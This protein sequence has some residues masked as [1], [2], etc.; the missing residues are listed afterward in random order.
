M[1]C[2]QRRHPTHGHLHASTRHGDSGGSLARSAS[3]FFSRQRLERLLP[4]GERLP[5][6][7]RRPNMVSCGHCVVRGGRAGMAVAIRCAPWLDFPWLGCDTAVEVSKA[8]ELYEETRTGFIQAVQ[9]AVLYVSVGDARIG[10]GGRRGVRLSPAIICT[11]HSPVFAAL[12]LHLVAGL[13]AGCTPTHRPLAQTRNASA[14]AASPR[15]K[16]SRTTTWSSS[17]RPAGPVELA[18]AGGAPG[19]AARRRPDPIPTVPA[20]PGLHPRQRHRRRPCSRR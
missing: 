8:L 2:Q 4:L 16:A 17:P 12:A 13:C 1:H 10:G 5:H 19:P 9:I 6:L 11:M 20:G 14:C 3:G 18:L 7:R 15:P